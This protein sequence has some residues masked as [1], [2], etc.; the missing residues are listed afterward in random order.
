M[1]DGRW[2]LGPSETWRGVAFAVIVAASL[3]P[4]MGLSWRAGALVG[5]TAMAGDCMASFLKRRLGLAV[6]NMALGL[7]Q[8][9][10]SLFPAISMRAYV[11][12]T[13]IDILIVVLLFS[14]GELAL[15]RVF[16]RLGLRDRPH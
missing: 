11:Q 5:A 1:R 7:D 12:L 4:L 14:V 2:L 9:P 8:V 16:F 3:S 10:E 13:A 6:S 15:S